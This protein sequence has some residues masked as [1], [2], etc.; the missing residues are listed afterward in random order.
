M[1]TLQVLEHN[2]RQLLER[3]GS[4]LDSFL[5]GHGMTGASAQAM[6]GE[7]LLLMQ[8]T[9]DEHLRPNARGIAAVAPHRLRVLLDYETYARLQPAERQALE[10]ELKIS[11]EQYINDRRYQVNGEVTL[12]LSY[13]PIGRVPVVLAQ[14]DDEEKRN[15][16]DAHPPAQPARAYRLVGSEGRNFLLKDLLP[17]GAAAGVGRARDN[18]VVIDDESVSKFHARLAL[19]DD[20]QLVVADCGSTNGTFVNGTRISKRYPLAPGDRITFG[21]IELRLER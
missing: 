21:D 5:S 15:T 9:I 19:S 2:L 14:F 18:S 16:N 3:L 10:R 17:G 7:L 1:K 6:L 11:A 12:T 8:R 13:D 4:K 20:G